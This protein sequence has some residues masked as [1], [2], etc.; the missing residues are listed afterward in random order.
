MTLVMGG[1]SSM[2]SHSNNIYVVNKLN[3][4]GNIKI[5]LSDGSS[6]AYI[7]DN[8]KYY[9]Y[10]VCMGDWY[11]ILGSEVDLSNCVNTYIDSSVTL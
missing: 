8:N 4:N 6:I 11:L 9:F 10:L 2:I 7:K 5:F 3:N 1:S